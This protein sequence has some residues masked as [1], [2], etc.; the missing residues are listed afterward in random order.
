MSH[1]INFYALP[2][3]TTFSLTN[4]SF[5][6]VLRAVNDAAHCSP[7]E[8]IDLISKLLDSNQDLDAEQRSLLVF[9]RL[10]Q[11][12]IMADEPFELGA[13]N[14]THPYQTLAMLLIHG[15]NA[16]IDNSFDFCERD[17]F[18][19]G[20]TPIIEKP[21]SN[22]YLMA[23]VYAL[24]ALSS[25]DNPIKAMNDHILAGE[26]YIKIGNTHEAYTHQ[27][28][29]C[30]YASLIDPKSHLLATLSSQG[31]GGQESSFQ[32]LM[33][34][35]LLAKIEMV[36]SKDQ[37]AETDYAIALEIDSLTLQGYPVEQFLK[38]LNAMLADLAS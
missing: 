5:Q 36:N 2:T 31:F 24:S 29:Y 34:K 18:L 35:V 25:S 19:S 1:S 14:L 15:H 17:L 9:L 13:N 3:P 37:E 6:R 21:S 20:L 33:K 32:T 38:K 8:I 30:F 26:A 11:H 28:Y 22:D 12:C 4:N 27:I 10:K 16:L 23:E 7:K